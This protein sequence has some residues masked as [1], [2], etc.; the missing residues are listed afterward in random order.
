[1]P[2]KLRIISNRVAAQQSWGAPSRGGLNDH[3][4]FALTERVRELRLVVAVDKIVEPR[5]AAELVHALRD[6]VARGV[7]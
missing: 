4:A 3:L 6:L 2:V 1:M 7:A 5:L